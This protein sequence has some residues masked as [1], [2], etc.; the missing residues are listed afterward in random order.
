MNGPSRAGGVEGVLLLLL[1]G[2]LLHQLFEGRETLLKRV[3]L[4]AKLLDLFGLPLKLKRLGVERL[5]GRGGDPDRV[6]YA[7]G[8]V[9]R[10]ELEGSVEVF[11]HRAEVARLLALGDVVP[12]RD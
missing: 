1:L 3:D 12:G 4:V 2:L 8:L 6:L 5:D 7:D 10:A 11:G 9:S